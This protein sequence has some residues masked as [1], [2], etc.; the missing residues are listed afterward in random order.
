[1]RFVVYDLTNRAWN[2][3]S[4]FKS[5][6]CPQAIKRDEPEAL[7]F[8]SANQ[9]NVFSWQFFLI[10]TTLRM[11]LFANSLGGLGLFRRSLS[12][13]PKIRYIKL[14]RAVADLGGAVG[15]KCPPF[16]DEKSAWRPLFG[17]KSTAYPDP[18]HPYSRFV[19]NV[20]RI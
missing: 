3:F 10:C 1:M 14:C 15:G 5:Q 2:P 19:L 16:H 9:E 4:A 7:C 20:G 6:A 11:A 13:A 12:T 8:Q 17:K 18:M